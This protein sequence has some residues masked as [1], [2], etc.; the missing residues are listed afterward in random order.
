MKYG[1][2]MLDSAKIIDEQE[3]P[4]HILSKLTF[5]LQASVLTPDDVRQ[6]LSVDMQGA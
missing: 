6:V 2:I 1:R 3:I 4:A 5:T